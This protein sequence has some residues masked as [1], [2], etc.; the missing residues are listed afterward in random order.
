MISL[1]MTML[2]ITQQPQLSH[3][4]SFIKTP[5]TTTVKFIT[6][7]TNP[8]QVYDPSTDAWGEKNYILY[9]LGETRREA[10]Q[11]GYYCQEREIKL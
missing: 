8:R 9:S 4:D 6:Y 11:A 2:L 10:N 7:S 1:W 5:E 3:W